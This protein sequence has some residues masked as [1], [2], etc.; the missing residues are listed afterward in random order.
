MSKDV[1]DLDVLTPLTLKRK[2][3]NW[4]AVYHLLYISWL[5]VSD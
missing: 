4:F 3:A 5:R 1:L 2:P